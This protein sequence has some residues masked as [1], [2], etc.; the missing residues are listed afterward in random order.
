MQLVREKNSLPFFY[1]QLCCKSL[2]YNLKKMK[3]AKKYKLKGKNL[4]SNGN[5]IM[6]MKYAV[7]RNVVE[8]ENSLLVLEFI[9]CYIFSQVCGIESMIALCFHKIFR[10]RSFKE[11]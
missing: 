11:L 2:K 4:K 5:I 6:L 8:M 1:F 7:E 10:S 9:L 3:I